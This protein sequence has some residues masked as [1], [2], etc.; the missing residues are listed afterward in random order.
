V[1]ELD[2]L[3]DELANPDG[4]DNWDLV[5]PEYSRIRKPNA[6][7][8]SDLSH[9]NYHEMRSHVQSRLYLIRTAIDRFIHRWVGDRWLP[10]YQMVGGRC[11]QCYACLC[12]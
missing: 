2:R 8:I 6:D 4:S 3:L 9:G 7:A 10:L 12:T 5:L 1:T 11:I